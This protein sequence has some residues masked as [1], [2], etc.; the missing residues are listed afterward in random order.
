[1]NMSGRILEGLTSSIRLAPLVAGCSPA[2]Y[3]CREQ[4]TT[5][6][7]RRRQHGAGK[8]R[9]VHNRPDGRDGRG[10]AG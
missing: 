1:M 9:A 2:P 6:G 8:S 5:H 10:R 4:G 3:L 7:R